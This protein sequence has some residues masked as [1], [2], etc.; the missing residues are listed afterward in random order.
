[1]RPTGLLGIVGVW[2]YRLLVRP[3][4]RRRCLHDESCSAFAIRMFGQHGLL[5]ALPLVRARVRG[6]R[7]PATACFVVDE[8][9]SRLLSATT[10]DGSTPPARAI[11]LLAA[12]ARGD[13]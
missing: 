8:A 13:V 11:E 4:L 6:C 12:R 3:F 7:L 10:H 2:V 9:G 5:H 1:M